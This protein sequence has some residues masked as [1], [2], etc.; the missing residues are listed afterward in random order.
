MEKFEF[1]SPTR[2]VFGRDTQKKVGAEVKNAGG[3]KALI[4]YGGQS[5]VK[6]GLLAE[7]EAS[8]KEAGV[9]FCSMGGV[10]PNPRLSFTR[11]AIKLICAEEVDFVLAVGGGSVIDCAKAAAAGA[12]FDGD[13]WDFFERKAVPT[14]TLPLGVVLTIPAAGSETSR[15]MVI[16]NDEF[17][18]GWLKRGLINQNIRASFAIL[19]PEL[20]YTLPPY[21]TACGV[22]DIMMHTMERFFSPENDTDL[23]D[24]IAEAIL[25][26]LIKNGPIALANPTDYEARSEIMWAGSLSHNDLTGLGRSMDFATHQLEHELSGLHDVAHGAGLAAMWGAWARYVMPKAIWRFFKFAVD[27]WGCEADYL[28]PAKTALAGIEKTEGF[29]ASLGMPK[30]LR[31]LIASYNLPDLTP[32]QIEDMTK[33]CSFFGKRTIGSLVVLTEDDIRKIY[34]LALLL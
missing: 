10:M 33:K 23:T 28:N 2:I 7:V 27:V 16:T 5:A 8:L 17:A 12:C 13:V 26:T 31:E 1:Q 29:F 9:S 24:R 30:T 32:A 18:G 4:L 15:S 19:N 14:E 34:Q 20:T 21:Q 25:A 6:S 3:K 11:Q 22:V